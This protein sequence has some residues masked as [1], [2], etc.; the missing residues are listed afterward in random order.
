MINPTPRNGTNFKRMRIGLLGG[1]FNPAHEGHREMS[2]YAL[3]KL[4][5]DQVWWLVSPLN[6]LKNKKDMLPLAVRLA[7]ARHMIGPQPRL[8]ATALESDLGTRFTLDTIKALRRHMPETHF[9]WLMGADN[10]LDIWRWRRWEQ[11]FAAVPIAVFRRPGYVAGCGKGPA[12]ARFAA[13]WQKRGSEK[14]LATQQPPA[15]CLLENRDN[16]LSATQLR[17]D[18]RKNV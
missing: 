9:V 15:W 10:L 11:L 6:P 7:R 1:S 17:Q 16:R 13:F 18:K 5:L 4:N 12:A 3:K 8:V 2:L 14:R